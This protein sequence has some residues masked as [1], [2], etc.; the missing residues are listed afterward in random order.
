MDYI[1][2]I[3]SSFLFLIMVVLVLLT[4]SSILP[5]NTDDDFYSGTAFLSAVESVPVY[6]VSIANP[7]WG[8]YPYMYKLE[9]YVG[10][11]QNI[12]LMDGNYRYGVIKDKDYFYDV[13]VSANAPYG[14]LVMYENFD[15]FDYLDNLTVEPDG[16]INAGILLLQQPSTLTTN[17]SIY[18]Y[19]GFLST[20]SDL[21]TVYISHSSDSNN[22]F[23]RFSDSAI[24][25]GKTE[26]GTQTLLKTTSYSKTT[27]WHRVFFGYTKDNLI[28]CNAGNTDS[29]YSDTNQIPKAK[30]VFSTSYNNALIDELYIYLNND[31]TSDSNSQRVTG[32]YIDANFTMDL[33]AITIKDGNKTSMLGLDFD[34]NL[35]NPDSQGITLVKADAQENKLAFFPQSK[36]FW[37]FKDAD[38]NIGFILDENTGLDLNINGIGNLGLWLDASTLELSDGASVGTWP[39]MS[40]NN[41]DATQTDDG[42]KPIFKKGIINGKPTVRFNNSALLT[43][44]MSFDD[45]TIF[46]TFNDLSSV[47]TFERI[48]DHSFSSGFWFGRNHGV[49]N[50]WGGGVKESSEPWGRYITVNDGQWNI[51][52]NIRNGT[53]H[54]IRSG[55]A[56][57]SGTVTSEPTDTKTI[58]IG[59]WQTQQ[60]DQRATNMD[61]AEILIYNVALP[62]SNRLLVENYL[63]QK[64]DI[65]VESGVDF[66]GNK[67]ELIDLN[68]NL[69]K[70]LVE[71]FDKNTLLPVDCNYN[72]KNKKITIGSCQSDTVIKIRFQL[73][74]IAGDFPSIPKLSITKTTEHIISKEKFDSLSSQSFYIRLY[75]K[76][77]Y[78]ENKADRPTGKVYKNFT[79]LLYS[80]GFAEN[81]AVELKTF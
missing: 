15:D 76:V 10:V 52:E 61:I 43:P 72:Y 56:V 64:Y 46:V 63:S 70:M 47:T 1:D 81:V 67:I 62:D 28:T 8:I 22:Y 26:N 68:S 9:N 37:L 3:I 11:S 2:W 48:L 30:L 79:K 21:L 80:N 57:A 77:T 35:N 74:G 25:I 6:N 39:D 71:F 44:E 50:S 42:N 17:E 12:G 31:L 38:E 40:G 58:G 73:D 24:Y 16:N 78:L 36:E 5:I 51:I 23:C 7:D 69:K 45:W 27:D 60:T 54:T 75:N 41:Y 66:I 4:I 34:R 49:S 19:F 29:N 13:N 20:T 65:N 32:N 55:N 33:G 14:V 18:D 59:A 53:T